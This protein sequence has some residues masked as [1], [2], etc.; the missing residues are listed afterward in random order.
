MPSTRYSQK[1]LAA[2][3]DELLKR[4]GIEKG[5]VWITHLVIG[6]SIIQCE[7]EK[8]R[9]KFA[10]RLHSTENNVNAQFDRFGLI[11]PKQ[12]NNNNNYH[13]QLH[14]FLRRCPALFI[15]NS[16]TN[17]CGDQVGLTSTASNSLSF[18]T[19]AL[20][21]VQTLLHV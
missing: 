20:T 4:S 21:Q 8:V 19:P 7:A 3:L 11:A 14:S 9:N 17:T 2:I 18:S 6:G 12:S 13:V 10:V 15:K 5:E 1:L 16:C